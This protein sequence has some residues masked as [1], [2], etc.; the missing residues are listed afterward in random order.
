MKLRILTR[1]LINLRGADI[2]PNVYDAKNYDWADSGKVWFECDTP[3]HNVSEQFV[4]NLLTY[5]SND[6]IK[7]EVIE[8]NVESHYARSIQEAHDYFLKP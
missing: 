4:E 2:V 5:E 7:Y 1:E 8:Y 3:Y 6:L